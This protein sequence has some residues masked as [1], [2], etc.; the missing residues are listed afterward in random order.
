MIT[1]KEIKT[2]ERIAKRLCTQGPCHADNIATY[3]RIMKQAAEAEFT[4]DNTSTLCHFLHEMFMLSQPAIMLVDICKVV[5]KRL[6]EERVAACHKLKLRLVE[7]TDDYPISL[8]DEINTL[9]K[10]LELL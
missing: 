8:D 10:L 5:A 6:I 2:L 9:N 1:A 4:E 3:Y 7:Y